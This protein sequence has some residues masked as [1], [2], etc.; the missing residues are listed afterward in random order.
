M[1]SNEEEEYNECVGEMEEH[2]L[3]HEYIDSAEYLQDVK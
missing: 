2:E 3:Q 1:E